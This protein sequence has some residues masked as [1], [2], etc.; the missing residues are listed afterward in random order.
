MPNSINFTPER[1]RAAKLSEGQSQT[2][3]RD[4]NSKAPG[5]GLRITA[6]KK[7]FI[8]EAR[9][10]HGKPIR[11]SMGNAEV[12]VLEDARRKAREYQSMIDEGRDPREVIKAS[13]K[14]DDDSRAKAAALGATVQKAWDEY[15]AYQKNRMPVASIERGKKWGERHLLDHER[16]TQKG[17]QKKIRGSGKTKPGVLVPLMNKKLSA[18]D[19]DLLA[20]WVLNESKSRANS[21]RQAFE[22]FRAFWRWCSDHKVYKSVID[23]S[24]LEEKD[25]LDRVPSRKTKGR[26]NDVIRKAQLASWFDAVRGLSNPVQSVYLQGLLITGA[27]REELAELKWADIDF[28][29]DVMSLHDKVEKT[30]E[31]MIPLTPYLRH[32]IES[33]PRVNK[34]VFS[35]P[36][37]KSGRISEPRI[38]H[39]RALTVAGI[40]HVTIHGLRRSF[41]TLSEWIEM[42]RGMVAQIAGHKPSATAEKHYIDREL[43]LLAIWHTKL[44]A[45]FLEEAGIH[46]EP[47]QNRL[48]AVK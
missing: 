23:A 14:K 26:A 7:T 48:R 19:S 2:F 43:G 21:A 44:E 28:Q 34:W 25:L 32:L 38:A 5:L 13:A 18:I 4:S 6:G 45:F 10:K 30:G 16:M 17:G 39:N 9:L 33:L 20:D 29:W 11:M 47:T 37:S 8:F 3:L 22:A 12:M 35:S 41:N 27:R 40:Q 31:R 36:T 46:F 1:I 15:I 24:V 42:P